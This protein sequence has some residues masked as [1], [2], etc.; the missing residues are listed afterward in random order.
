MTIEAT[1]LL[2]DAWATYYKVATQEDTKICN[3]TPSW[4]TPTTPYDFAA[5]LCKSLI[6]L[7]YD[8]WNAPDKEYYTQAIWDRM[9]DCG[10]VLPLRD[11]NRLFQEII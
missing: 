4:L 10:E 3:Q 11:V 1:K 5:L 8:F 9:S 7:A 6:P 2:D